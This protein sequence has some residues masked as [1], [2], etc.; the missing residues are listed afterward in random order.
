M[1]RSS[2]TH[3]AS[4]HP[5]FGGGL[6]GDGGESPTREIGDVFELVTLKGGERSIRSGAFGE[7]MHVGSGPRSEALT[8]HVGQQRLV[9]RLLAWQEP[10]PFVL[11]DVGLGPAGNVLTALEAL[12]ETQSVSAR[13]AALWPLEIHSMEIS[14]EILKF[15]LHHAPELGYLAGWEG[16]VEELLEKGVT[17]P[18]PGVRWQLHRG[19]FSRQMPDVAVMPPAHAIFHDP[20]S[21]AKNPE[22]WSVELFRA[23]RERCADACLLTNYTRSTAIR[24][25]LLLAGWAVGRGVAT[26]EKDQTTLAATECALLADPLDAEWL[27]RVRRSV[28]AA[29]FRGG[30]YARGPIAPEDLAILEALPQFAER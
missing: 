12:R 8:L 20:Y 19:D 23:M 2:S 25:T 27:G 17:S 15:A 4:A 7:T 22:M 10:C 5:S 24:V 16:A 11:W 3:C 6:Q 26:G 9:E 14:T 28:N 30:V 29:P 1:S 18:L 13:G 21:P